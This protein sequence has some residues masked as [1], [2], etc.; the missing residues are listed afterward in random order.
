LAKW[1]IDKGKKPTGGR[2]NL[3]RKK[4][5]FQIMGMPLLTELGEK[6]TRKSRGRGGTE[7]NRLVYGET[8]NVV[9]KGNKIKKVKII[10]VKE[11]EAN[12]HYVRRRIITKGTIL[13]TEAGDVRVT[14]RP[15]QDG[16]LNG[17][18]VEEKAK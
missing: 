3:Q 9:G 4:R 7:K 12:P 15:S 13:E 17:V 2:I 10:D 8:V 6:K 11:N 16:V 18:L 14:N 5:K 1:N